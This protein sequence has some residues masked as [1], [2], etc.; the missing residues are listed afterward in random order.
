MIQKLSHRVI[1]LLLVA[2][3]GLQVTSA[4]AYVHELPAEGAS[5]SS[6]M[7]MSKDHAKKSAASHCPDTHV[8]A[9]PAALP[10]PMV[11]ADSPPT[12][13]HFLPIATAVPDRDPG[14]LLRPP[15]PAA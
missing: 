7:A 14:S 13:G 15:R 2:A 1:C 3:L 10:A 5:D 4:I 6:L 8:C 9:M 11:L 12:A